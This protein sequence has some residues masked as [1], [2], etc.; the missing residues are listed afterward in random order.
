MTFYNE[1]NT[2]D[3]KQQIHTLFETQ[4]YVELYQTQAETLNHMLLIETLEEFKDFLDSESS[5]D[6]NVFWMY[7][8][9]V[10]GE[11]LSIGGYEGDV[12]ETVTAFLMEKLPET[13]FDRI[14]NLLQDLYADLDEQDTLEEIIDLCNQ[15]LADTG[16]TLRLDFDDTYCAGEYFLTVTHP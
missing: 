10:S 16:Y 1:N 2:A 12:T 13:F 5:L 3:I 6:E 9:A 8:A 14:R 11:S 15:S 7:H 4:N